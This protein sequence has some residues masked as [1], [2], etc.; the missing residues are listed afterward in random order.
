MLYKSCSHLPKY[1]CS[2][3]YCTQSLY[4][5]PSREDDFSSRALYPPIEKPCKEDPEKKYSNGLKRQQTVEEKLFLVNVPRAWGWKCFMV[6]EGTIPFNNLKFAQHVTRTHLIKDH[7]LPDFYNRTTK[8]ASTLTSQMQQYVA[9]SLE[10]Q[11]HVGHRK[12]L[13]GI[14]DIERDKQTTNIIVSEL[15]RVIM[16]SLKTHGYD[17]MSFQVDYSPRIEASWKLNSLNETV[18]EKNYPEGI[19]LHELPEE[20]LERPSDKY[21]QYIGHPILQLRHAHPLP[22]LLDKRSANI[23]N[24]SV[25]AFD[26]DPHVALGYNM[27]RRHITNIPGFWPGDNR[28]FSFLSYHSSNHIAHRPQAYGSTDAEEAVQS[29]IILASFGWLMS[30]ACYQ[31]FSVYNDVTYPLVTQT[32]ATDGKKFVFGVVQLNT[33]EIHHKNHYENPCCNIC[34]IT[35]EMTLFDEYKSG[36]LIGF[37][38]KVLEVLLQF[39]INRPEP[40]QG[41]KLKPY[42]GQEV[43]HI[44]DYEDIEKREWLEHQFKHFSSNRPPSRRDLMYEV[45]DWERIFK[46]Q[47][48]RRP[49]D[50]RKRPF[51]LR[52]N[53]Y[54]LQMNEIKSAYIP[55]HLRPDKYLPKWRQRKRI[56]TFFP[57]W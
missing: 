9:E 56:K 29:Q 17:T 41:V 26:Y 2:A 38:E 16:N 18:V 50:A 30:L 55:K 57:E 28:E 12:L 15:N 47:Y 10:Y 21:I 34:W 36:K 8:E 43:K 14:T 31:G 25:P 48:R 40:L 20:Y 6:H 37:N 32:V 3:K 7:R 24:F 19:P 53:P 46:I 52:Q 4:K 44:A 13:E 1:R 49:Q 33:T 11:L 23:F 35:K 51:E 54:H 39:Y 5:H 42:L 45:D 27:E 22:S